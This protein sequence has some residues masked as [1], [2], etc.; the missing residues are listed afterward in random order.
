MAYALVG[1]LG[2]AVSAAAN[3]TVTPAYGQTPTANNLLIC[4][5]TDGGGVTLPPTPSGWTSAV[6]EAAT[7]ACATA[8]FYKIAAGSDAQPSFTALS[9]TVWS[10][11]LGEFS[12]N[13]TS[14]PLDR[15][16]AGR[17][18]A[19]PAAATAATADAA[20]GELLIA[21]SMAR[22]SAFSGTTSDT[23]NNGATTHDT[24][25][26]GSNVNQYGFAWGITTGNSAGDS[27]NWTFPTANLN[28][29]VTVIASFKLAATINT[30][31]MF[32]PIRG[33]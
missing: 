12:G 29:A 13:P 28:N 20:Q 26:G 8:I 15:T 10:A 3:T 9:G 7:S 11:M 19:S 24:V 27:N 5:A 6:S 33:G 22:Y 2:A 25:R 14:S 16:A 21:C 32:F 30:G 4:W 31:S 1:S 23:L 18:T 17:G